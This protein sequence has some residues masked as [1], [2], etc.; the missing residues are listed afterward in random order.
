MVCRW[1]LYAKD[2]PLVAQDQV[3]S[4]VNVLI[5]C[6]LVAINSTE[7]RLLCDHFQLRIMYYDLAFV[8]VEAKTETI[9]KNAVSMILR[10]SWTKWSAREPPL[11][12]H[13]YFRLLFILGHLVNRARR[14]F[15]PL[16]TRPLTL[17]A[18][19]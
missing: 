8:L 10:S 6:A 17:A 19:S 12:Q 7:C 4:Q 2:K 16:L 15:S 13:E 3:R 9:H 14:Q 11:S 5:L 1:E 18:I